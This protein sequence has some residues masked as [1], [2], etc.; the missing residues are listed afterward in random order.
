MA[1]CMSIEEQLNDDLKNA[2]RSKAADT[3][4]CIRQLKSKVQETVNA[5]GFSGPVDD[6]LHQKVIASYVKS[7]EKAIVELQAAGERSKPLC[8]KYAAEIAYLGKYMPKMMSEAETLALVKKT[9]AALG[10]TDPKQAGKVLGAL[11]KEHKGSIDAG[12]AKGLVEKT[13]SGA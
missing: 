12:L 1:G 11:M 13:L 8:D 6:A 3:V 7:L 4:A 2:M 9:I 10:V 5:K